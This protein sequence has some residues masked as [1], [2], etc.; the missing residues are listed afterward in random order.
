MKVLQES[1]NWRQ[2]MDN[3]D[4]EC[5]CGHAR[6]RHQFACTQWVGAKNNPPFYRLVCPCMK[7]EMS[8]NAI[9][10]EARLIEDET[11]VV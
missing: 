10:E 8:F 1:L 5:V 11:R 7:F 4:T 9:I 6:R 2:M 3:L